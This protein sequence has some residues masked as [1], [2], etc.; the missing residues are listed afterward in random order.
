MCVAAAVA[1]VDHTPDTAEAEVGAVAWRTARCAAAV[2][3]CCL[4]KEL[5]VVCFGGPRFLP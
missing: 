5:E 1:V 3:A 2:L 4:G